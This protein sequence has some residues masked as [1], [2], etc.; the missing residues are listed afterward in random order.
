MKMTILSASVGSGHMRAAQAVEKAAL[1]LYPLAQVRVV[2]VLDLASTSFRKVYGEGYLGL[3]ASA[4]HLLG[5]LYDTL[6]R[7]PSMSPMTDSVRRFIQRWSMSAFP[8]FLSEEKPDVIVNTHFL[9]AE[10]IAALRLRGQTRVPQI[11]VTTDFEAHRF[12]AHRP[13]EHFF[14]ASAESAGCLRQWGVDDECITPSGIPIDP[15]FSRLPARAVCLENHGLRGD[16]PIVLQLAGGNGMGPI[17][18]I[19]SQLLSTRAPLEIV[20]VTG[21]NQE[22]RRKLLNRIVPARHR[23]HVMGYTAHMHELMAAAD[24]VVSKPGGLT[25]SE[26]L[27]CGVPM[28]VVNPIPGQESRN[29]DFVLEN[30]AGIKANTLASLSDKIDALLIDPERL[31]TMRENAR[32]LGK[33]CAAYDVARFAAALAQKGVQPARTARWSSAATIEI[34]VA[35]PNQ[36]NITTH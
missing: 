23:A 28:V 31:G 16:R 7:P 35:A 26:T 22:A 30:G 15:V 8:D 13:C 6:D 36:K 9:P 3:A 5:Y 2:D 20:V 34:R 25:T 14:T 4:P 32:R 19:Y 10:L 21:R 12:W 24:L 27:A 18:E 33:P 17:E 1:E 11:T 29:G